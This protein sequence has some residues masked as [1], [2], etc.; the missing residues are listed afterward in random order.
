MQFDSNIL[1]KTDQCVMC[2]LCLPHCPTY[3][4]SQHESESPRGRISL[5]K[6]MTQGQLKP[7]SSLEEHLQ[8]CTACYK[9]ETVCPAKVP[10]REILDYGR[11][12]YRPNLKSANKILQTMSLTMLTHRWGHRSLH[13]LAKVNRLL[14]LPSSQ[15][16]KHIASIKFNPTLNNNQAKQSTNVMLFTGCTGQVF[17]QQ[18]IKSSQQLIS[19]LGINT[20]V[21]K[22]TL[23]CS[24]LA[25]HSGH[26]VKA[27]IQRKQL[28]IYLEQHQINELISFTTGCGQ[29]LDDS[30][31]ALTY[32]HLD[33]HTWLEK[34]HLS[35]KVTFRPLAKKVL[36]H[37]PCS[38]QHKPSSVQAMLSLL[39]NIPE[40]NILQ[41]NDDNLCCGAG[42]MQLLT[43]NTSNLA[44]RQAK[45]SGIKQSK[46]DIIVTPNI[47]C[48]LQLTH[49]LDAFNKTIHVMHPITLLANQ[50]Q[51]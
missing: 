7:S 17:D 47:G 43:P 21:T 5:I 27:E 50:V 22:N 10:Y 24:A 6:A 44:L 26:T 48:R 34:H 20:H 51:G 49:G 12:Q 28:I 8:S 46:P 33:I 1:K 41:F 18:V 29:Q 32:K 36:V 3:K 19:L 16:L 30:F 39:K 11:S 45:I 9:C 13:L 14:P 2:G 25:Q 38:M 4:V 15:I 42:G 31:S 40:I 23:C 37:I 35:K